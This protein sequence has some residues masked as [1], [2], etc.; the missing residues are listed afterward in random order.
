MSGAEIS[1]IKCSKREIEIIACICN[2]CSSKITA[3]ILNISHHTVNTHIK[4]IMSKTNCYSKGAILRFVETSEEYISVRDKYIEIKFTSEF[5]YSDKAIQDYVTKNKQGNSLAIEKQQNKLDKKHIYSF[6]LTV[7]LLCS[8]CIGFFSFYAKEEGN[9]SY[10]IPLINEQILL[11]RKEIINEMDKIFASKNTLK[12]IVLIGEAGAGKTT[13]A[14]S[15]IR[16]NKFSVKAE[17]DAES[18]FKIISSFL[19][20]LFLLSKTEE[21]KNMLKTI[22]G[23]TNALEKRKKIKVF[24]AELLRKHKNWC[25]IYDNVEDLELLKFWLPLDGDLFKNGNIIITTKNKNIEH[26]AYPFPLQVIKVGTLSL[27][28]SE[29]LFYSILDRENKKF[30]YDEKCV[31]AFLKEI[32]AVP[33][34]ISSAAYFLRINDITLE[35][36]IELLKEKG[37]KHMNNKI[38]KEV[39]DYNGTRDTIIETTFEKILEDSK[40]NLE[41]L[42]MLCLLDSQN[43]NKQYR[44]SKNGNDVVFS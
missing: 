38:A 27:E 42:L 25:L 31:K 8:L 28:E 13:L 23:I 17:I 39:M 26:G 35:K 5:K 2:G 36:Y 4:N 15:Y 34:D 14:R 6:T 3:N 22:N 41:L 9:I 16:K 7:T 43:I 44:P 30:D 19:E 11:P 40:D 10:E 32:P 29:K 20:L 12:F 1:G 33:L 21:H 18:E 24:L 37:V